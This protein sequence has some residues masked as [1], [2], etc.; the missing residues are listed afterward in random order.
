MLK[1]IAASRWRE[2]IKQK[3][4][5]PLQELIREINFV[6]PPRNFKEALLRPSQV[7]IIAEI[8]KFSPSGGFEEYSLANKKSPGEIAL[9]Y[10]K[11]GAAAI[12]VLTEGKYFGGSPADLRQVK[13]TVKIPV[14]RKDFILDEYQIYE[15]R[16]M[17]ADAV[18]LIAS[19][20]AFA[21]LQ[22]F[23]Q[24]AGELGMA[25][26]VEA[27]RK[28]EIFLAVK[29]GAQIIGINNRNLHTMEVDLNRTL[30]WGPYVPRDRVLVSESGIF[31]RE[32]IRQLKQISGIDAV[33]V[34]KSLIASEDPSA[35]IKELMG[36]DAPC[37]R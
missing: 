33:L 35:K 20:L 28:E 3:K 4:T 26:I 19:L 7:S 18:L 34:G 16:A 36:E 22:R 2:V 31:S 1:E 27:G 12:S 13:E 37:P 14:L 32:Q 25:A 21:E 29:A 24:L 23:L 5:Y 17:G 15:S 10:E 8:K 6:A 9:L 11:G 30:Q